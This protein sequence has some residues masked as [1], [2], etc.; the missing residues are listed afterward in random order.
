MATKASND[1]HQQIRIYN[2]NPSSVMIS[3][4][5]WPFL[6]RFL[7]RRSQAGS[8]FQSFRHPYYH[9]IFIKEAFISR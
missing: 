2:K 8:S 1:F 3:A 4:G 9:C 7:N 6:T 5:L